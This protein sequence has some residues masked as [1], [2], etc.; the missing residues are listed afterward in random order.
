MYPCPLKINTH[1]CLIQLEYLALS[2]VC[3]LGS[4]VGQIKQLF[5][6][7]HRV[8]ILL[9]IRNGTASILIKW[10][11]TKSIGFGIV[12]LISC[13]QRTKFIKLS[14]S[15]IFLISSAQLDFLCPKS[16]G[17]IGR[18]LCVLGYNNIHSHCPSVTAQLSTKYLASSQISTSAPG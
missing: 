18:S 10:C 9:P 13:L 6:F 3:L 14:G 5:A 15:K 12:Y 16:S 1:T 2:M 8:I 4:F 11:Q 17:L 7:I